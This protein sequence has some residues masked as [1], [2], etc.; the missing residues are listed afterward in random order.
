VVRYQCIDAASLEIISIALES[1]LP[2]TLVV[3]T[4]YNP[5]G[6]LTTM[7]ETGYIGKVDDVIVV[8]SRVTRLVEPRDI[9]GNP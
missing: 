2:V 5:L 3:A 8:E 1:D 7:L 9:S 4:P 6:L